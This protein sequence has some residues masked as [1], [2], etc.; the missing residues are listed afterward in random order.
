MLLYAVVAAF[1]HDAKHYFDDA[2]P[3]D[4]YYATIFIAHA[5]FMI[6]ITIRA[7]AAMLI[8]DARC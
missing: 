5:V 8:F 1:F 2:M 7:F 4:S 3:P 6:F